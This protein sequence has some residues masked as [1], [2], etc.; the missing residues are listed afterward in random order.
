MPRLTLWNLPL[1]VD[2]V[3]R[4]QG[5]DARAAQAR[6]PLLLEAARKALEL[7]LP[8]VAPVVAYRRLSTAGLNH[9]RV[10]LAEGGYLQGKLV[11]NVLAA[12]RHVVTMLCTI[13][14]ALENYAASV[15]DVDPAL[16][17]AL[18]GL[19]TAAVEELAVAACSK[20]GA[21]AEHAGLQ[22]TIPLSPGMEGWDTGPGQKQLF[23]LFSPEEAGVT[24]TTGGMMLPKKS[25][26]LVLGLGENVG[27]QG[28]ACDYCSLRLTCRY[29]EQHA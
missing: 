7:G 8:L 22:A 26:S 21:E 11:A 16:G 19:G 13:G 15:M 23:A 10:L 25:V 9:E 3:F 24:L 27:K 4:G 5:I 20:F 28:Q 2:R 17:F 1:D 29:Q 14:P 6:K 18:D 12:T